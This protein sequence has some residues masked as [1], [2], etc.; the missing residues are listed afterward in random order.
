MAAATTSHDPSIPSDAD[1]NAHLGRAGEGAATTVVVVDDDDRFRAGLSELLVRYG[2]NVVG[3]AGD[4]KTAVER[5]A[6]T[7]PDVV[8]MDL[9]M[10]GTTSGLDATRW[11]AERSPRTAVLVLTVSADGEDVVDAMLAGAC[12]YL[13]KGTSPDALVAGIE[14]AARGES[15]ISAEVARSLFE[16]L[17]PEEREPERED[18]PT[19]LLSAREIEVL[20]LLARGRQNGD[21]AAELVLSPFT[22]RNHISNVL[23]KLQLENRTQAAA[24]AVRH[25]L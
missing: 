25:G 10:P 4:G 22:V 23:R 5:T 12:G 15:I 19:A 8:L 24:Y 16:R 21:I 9:Q 7:A 1:R 20:R 6:E 17:R 11:I 18:S 13:V 3:A 14:A 2:L